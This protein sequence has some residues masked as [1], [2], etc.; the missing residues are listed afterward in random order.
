MLEEGDVPAG[1]NVSP[2]GAVVAAV[3]VAMGL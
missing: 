1:R 2:G 3:V